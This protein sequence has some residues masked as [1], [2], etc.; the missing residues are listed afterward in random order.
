V[1]TLPDFST[2]EARLWLRGDI[3]LDTG[4]RIGAGRTV[5]P[6][7][8]DTP[9]L[10]DALGRPYIPGSSLKGALR[11][12]VERVLRTLQASAEVTD[13][14]LACDP[15]K[16]PSRP[17]EVP[18]DLCLYPEEARVILREERAETWPVHPTLQAIAPRVR[19]ALRRHPNAALP[20]LR[21]TLLWELSCRTCRLFGAPWLASRVLVRDLPIATPDWPTPIRDGVAIDRDTGT[22]HDKRKYDFETVAPG[23]RFRLLIQV[24]NPT[25]EDLGLLWLGVQALEKGQI[26]LGGA[27]SRGLGHVHLERDKEGTRYWDRDQGFGAWWDP[28]APW[29]RPVTEADVRAWSQAFFRSIGL[30]P[31]GH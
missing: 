10:R 27:R 29:G 3:V 12:F 17:A 14:N 8:P 4:F 6:T 31:P 1:G 28:E 30:T 7:Q 19:A 16:G 15:L 26:L 22:A 11:S 18:G 20:Q 5:S 25:P 9:I 2:L 24:E 23:A 21:D 13:P